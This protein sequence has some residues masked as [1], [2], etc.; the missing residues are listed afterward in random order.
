MR[1]VSVVGNAGSGKSLL[2]QRLADAL[3][4]PLMELDAIHHLPNWEPIDPGEFLATVSTLGGKSADRKVA[5]RQ[6][7]RADGRGLSDVGRSER[8]TSRP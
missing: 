2:A 4:V 1:R 7:P 8:S 3:D 5:A 6:W